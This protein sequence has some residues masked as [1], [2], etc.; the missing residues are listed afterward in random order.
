MAALDTNIV[1]RLM[2]DDDLAQ[3]R[4]A[5]RLVE[6]EACTVAPSVL[7]ECEWVL[8]SSIELDSATIL[9][10]FIELIDIDN[11]AVTEPALVATVLDAYSQGLD[12]ADAL[13]AAQCA[14]E[15]SLYTF[16]KT[17]AKRAAKMGLSQVR[18]L[19]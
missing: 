16:D 14:Q 6:S 13:H 8:R 19:K 3:G 17:F 12:F 10:S 11:I 4:L 2:L 5:L 1:L 9:A 18:L 7:M 15:E